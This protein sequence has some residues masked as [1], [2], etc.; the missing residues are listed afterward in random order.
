MTFRPSAPTT[1]SG[2]AFSN[3]TN[4]ARCVVEPR[5][6]LMGVSL[7]DNP[8]KPL[9]VCGCRLRSHKTALL[10]F[11]L[12][13]SLLAPGDKPVC[14][15]EKPVCVTV[16]RFVRPRFGMIFITKFRVT[17]PPQLIFFFNKNPSHPRS[18]S[19]CG[20]GIGI[21]PLNITSNIPKI[22]IQTAACTEILLHKDILCKHFKDTVPYF[23]AIIFIDISKIIDIHILNGIY[24][25]RLGMCQNFNHRFTECLLIVQPCQRIFFWM[26]LICSRLSATR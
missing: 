16:V 10:R 26:E 14:P 11:H 2:R 17:P 5:N 12:I 9:Q 1:S 3:A 6:C 19:A 8:P 22:R 4:G 25:I 7:P 23:I 21:H 13:K 15:P 24:F 18:C 20:K